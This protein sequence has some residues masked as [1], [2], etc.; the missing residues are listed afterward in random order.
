MSVQSKQSLDEFHAAH[1]ETL[2][3]WK[4]ERNQVSDGQK[5]KN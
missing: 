2:E 1:V 3:Q 5:D 4:K